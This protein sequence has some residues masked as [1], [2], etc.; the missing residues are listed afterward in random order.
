MH[1]LHVSTLNNTMKTFIVDE[2]KPVSEIAKDIARKLGLKNAE[3]FSLKRLQ[4]GDQ[5][6]MLAHNVVGG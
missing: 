6:G 1:P 5:D 2:S 4:Q 3:E